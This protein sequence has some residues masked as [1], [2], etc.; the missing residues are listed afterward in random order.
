M[1]QSEN[2]DLG[3][4]SIAIVI[5]VLDDWK[6]LSLL[7]PILDKYLSDKR[8]IV[9]IIVVDDGS[10]V[11][12]EEASPP[13]PL[14]LVHINKVSVLELKRNMGHQ[15][16][17][18]LGLAFVAAE[19]DC[20]AA[21]VMDGDGEDDPKDVVRLIDECERENFTKMIFARRSKRSENLIFRIFYELYKLFYK[22]L[23]GRTIRFGNF[24]IVP[25]KILRRLIVVSEVWNHYAVGALKARVPYREINTSRSHRLSDSSKMNFVSLVTHGLSAISVY[26]DLAGVRLLLGT[27]GLILLSV[28]GILTVVVVRLVTDLA[29]PGWAT[30]VVALLL[31]ILMQAVTLSLFFIFLVLNN[32]NNA[33]FLPERDY[34]YFISREHEIFVKK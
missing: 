31:I 24:S 22:I 23:T 15:R 8:L 11:S 26:G 18:T 13:L 16:A 34:S 30:Y 12:F 29:I 5:P 25:D 27:C 19:R 4:V 33:S 32:R 10:S 2:N 17:I 7:L 20:D 1:K 14:K 3:T 6:S 21:L 28:V 9:E